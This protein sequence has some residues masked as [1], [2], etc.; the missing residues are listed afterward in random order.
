MRHTETKAQIE[1]GW[2]KK[3]NCKSSGR[4]ENAGRLMCVVSL[5]TLI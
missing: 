4:V 2:G 1:T 3:K 5:L